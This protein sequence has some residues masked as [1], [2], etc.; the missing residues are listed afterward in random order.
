MNT[1]Y[2]G[3]GVGHIGAVKAQEPELISLDELSAMSG[4]GPQHQ[5]IQT[6]AMAIE[7]SSRA[8]NLPDV[9]V[10]GPEPEPESSGDEGEP[11][12]G[13]EDNSEQEDVFHDDLDL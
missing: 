2:T 6:S 12:E 1:R 10:S 9:D 4:S 13:N 5:G 11:E 3:L 7:G 8:E